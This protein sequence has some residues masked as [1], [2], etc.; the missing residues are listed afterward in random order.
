M[1]HLIIFNYKF[2]NFKIPKCKYTKL[3]LNDL[4]KLNIALADNIVPVTTLIPEMVRMIQTMLN[5]KNAYLADDGSIYFS[6]KSFKKYGQLA[7]L[8]MK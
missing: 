2:E 4:E 1:V 7:N 5:R 3:F 8:D 6:V